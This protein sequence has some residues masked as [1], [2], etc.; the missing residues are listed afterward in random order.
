MMK[1][2][3]INCLDPEESRI[4]VVEDGVLQEFYLERVS[5]ETLVG[6]IYKGRVINCLPGLAAA[7]VNIGLPHN[8]FLHASEVAGNLRVRAEEAHA[9]RE[10]ERNGEQGEGAVAAAAVSSA[11][12]P[13]RGRRGPNAAARAAGRSDEAG[14]EADLGA[15]L[16]ADLG[17]ETDEEREPGEMDGAEPAT[18]ADAVDDADAPES[19]E[20]AEDASPR[21]GPAPPAPIRAAAPPPESPFAPSRPRRDHQEWDINKLLQPGQE[22][23]VQVFRDG[24]G[25][26]GPSVTMDV[27]V[28]GRSL[29]LTP[30]VPRIAISKKIEDPGERE[31][32]RALLASLNPPSGLGFIIRTAGTDKSHRDLQSDMETL[33][34]TWEGIVRRAKGADAPALIYRESDLAIRTIRDVYTPDTQEVW[35]DS[36]V[37][38]ESALDFFK[39]SLPRQAQRV[40]LYEEPTPLFHRFGLE[41]QIDQLYHRRVDLPSGGYLVIDQTE[42]LIAIDVNSGRFTRER[43]P[44]EMAFQTNVEAATELVRQLRLRDLGGQIVVDF[45]DLREARHRQEIER[46]LREEMRRDRSRSTILKM[47][48]LGLVEIAREKARSGLKQLTYELCPSCRGTGLV[49]NVPAGALAVLR[50]IRLWLA[51]PGVASLVVHAHP[52]VAG[53]LLNDKR[54]ELAR[55]EEEFRAAIAVHPRPDARVEEVEIAA[56]DATNQRVN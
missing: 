4:A 43:S 12:V 52:Q 49:K 38:H 55:L 51:K 56:F 46:R 33:L 14:S 27:S 42:A 45:I 26:K 3:L 24:I 15:R 11:P 40:R 23:L 39:L 50:Q 1:R 21:R 28:P 13:A 10:R 44:E 2:M 16:G 25:E 47:S 48:R 20:A 36:P 6:N 34:Q 53:R 30:R 32:L 7:F 17:A 9:E 19:A 18:S 5:R 22:V 35:I 29:V 31:E 8:G 41:A 37:V 54:R